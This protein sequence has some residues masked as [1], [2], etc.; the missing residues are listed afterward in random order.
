MNFDI[1]IACL[2][3][4]LGELYGNFVWWGSLVTQIFLQN[5]IWFDIKSAIAL[6]NAAVL[7]SE[8]GLIAMLLR[9]N[10]IEKWMWIL[11][12]VSIIGAFLWANLLFIVPADVMKIVFTLAIIAIVI[13]N[14]IP[15]S[16][17]KPSDFILTKKSLGFLCLSL[18][19]VAVYNA[20][21]SIWDFLIGLL[22]L[23]SVFHFPYHKALFLITFVSVFT[24]GAAST[25]Y[26]RLWLIDINFYLPMFL[27]ALLAGLIAGYFV[28]KINNDILSKLLKYLSIFLA[29]YLIIDIFV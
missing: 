20:F 2:W 1:L 18:L 24:R 13:K 26:F 4:F 8:I 7:W 17:Q 19:F 5:I 16:E 29:F 12:W 9:N 14:F 6:D 22:I 3:I 25:E 11:V 28:Q 21:L 27:T 23:T 15:S 10:K